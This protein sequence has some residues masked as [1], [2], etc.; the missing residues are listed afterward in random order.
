MK[1]QHREQPSLDSWPGV[2]W[3]QTRALVVLARGLMKRPL[4]FPGVRFDLRGQCAGQVRIDSTGGGIIRYNAALLQRHGEDFVAQTVPHEVAHYAAF[5]EFGRG[6]RP[7]GREWQQ[8][9]QA[10]GGEP[11]RCHDYDTEGL[12]A[13]RTRWF[14]YHCHCGEHRLSSV[15]H[16]RIGRGARYRCRRCGKLLCAGVLPTE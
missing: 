15:R 12:T 2:A 11:K 7:H 3:E 4:P 1:R 9:V 6:I 10:L 5:L 16:D 8:I 13:R 14:A